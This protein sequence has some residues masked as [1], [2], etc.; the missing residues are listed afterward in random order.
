VLHLREAQSLPLLSLLGEIHI[1]EAVAAELIAHDQAWQKP[2]WIK[3]GALVTPHTAQALAWMQG[4]LLDAGEAAALALAQQLNADW[5]VT[6]DSAARLVAQVLGLEVHG[7]LGLVLWAA[8]DGLLAESEAKAAL[9]G[10]IQSSLWL[11]A[12]LIAEARASL[13][14]LF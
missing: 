13:E 2:I 12:R 14:E 5:F 4:G 3:V 9:E 6:D 7:S 10:L 11:S 8:A 1:P